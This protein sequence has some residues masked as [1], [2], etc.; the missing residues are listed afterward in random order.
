MKSGSISRRRMT[1][2]DAVPD[3]GVYEAYYNAK[4]AYGNG[5]LETGSLYYMDENCECPGIDYENYV[6]IMKEENYG[7][8]IASE[9]EG[10]D[11]DDTEQIKRHIAMLDK[12]WA[13][14]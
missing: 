13:K 9:Y 3:D 6:R 7:G 12:Y 10:T 1:P 11:P 2:V 4:S 14:Y 8:Y 5:Q